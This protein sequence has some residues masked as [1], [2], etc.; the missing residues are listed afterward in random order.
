MSQSTNC[1]KSLKEVELSLRKLRETTG[2]TSAHN[3]YTGEN[4]CEFSVVLLTVLLTLM[5]TTSRLLV[6]NDIR[7]SINFGFG[8]TPS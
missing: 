8:E 5:V 6:F 4:N 1:N 3:S 2:L 7:K